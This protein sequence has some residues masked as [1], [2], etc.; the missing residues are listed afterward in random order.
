MLAVDDVCACEPASIE[1]G[2]IMTARQQVPPEDPPEPTKPG[3]N[4]QDVEHDVRPETR[5]DNAGIE[6]K[7][8]RPKPDEGEGR[9]SRPD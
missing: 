2:F 9:K 1:G 3:V 6:V 4:I 8:R 7:P 5:V